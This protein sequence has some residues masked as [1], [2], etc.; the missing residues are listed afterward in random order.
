MLFDQPEL[1]I[2]LFSVPKGEEYAMIVKI[3]RI[4]NVASADP[5]QRM[6]LPITPAA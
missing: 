6:T 4:D 3:A 5:D 1:K 2:L